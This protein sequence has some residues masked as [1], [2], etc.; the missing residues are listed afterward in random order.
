MT[1]HRNCRSAVSKPSQDLD[2]GEEWRRFSPE[3][4]KEVMTLGADRSIWDL[5]GGKPWKTDDVAKLTGVSIPN[6][7]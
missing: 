3:Q 1:T 7:R 6:K 5:T 4:L 2:G